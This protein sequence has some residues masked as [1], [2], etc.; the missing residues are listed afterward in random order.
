MHCEI[1]KNKNYIILKKEF[2]FIFCYICIIQKECNEM[3]KIILPNFEG[4]FDLLLYFIKRDELNIYDIPISKITLEFLNYIKLMNFFDIELAGEFVVMAA[5]LM[6]IK[7]KMLLPKQINEDGNVEDPREQL[8][9]NLLEYKQFKN[10]AEKLSILA[11]A[12]KYYLYR[13]NFTAEILQAN[14]NVTYK[15]ATLYDLL[16]AFGTAIN[17]NTE[18]ESVHTVEMHTVSVKDKMIEITDKLSYDKRFTFSELVKNHSRNHIIVFF[19]AILELMKLGKLFIRQESSFS[20][21]II[22]EVPEI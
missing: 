18:K 1:K 14:H 21:F 17:R 5:N 9:Q 4:P 15:N 12:N 20:D 10:A 11:E 7:T 22:S 3:Y 8:I 19:L 16:I 2:I 6:Y 13:N